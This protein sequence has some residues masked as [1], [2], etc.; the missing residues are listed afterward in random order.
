MRKY[1]F[2]LL[3]I[4]YFNS[5]FADQCS[6]SEWGAN[7]EIGNANLI[8]A[9]S[10]LKAS[11]LIKTGKTYSLGLIIDAETPAYPPRS[12]SL[13]V[14]QPTQQFG[15]LGLP[16]STYNDDIFQGW[17]G[18]GSQI[19]GLGHI[20]TTEAMFY[21]CNDGKE[22][23][24]ITGLTKL[25]IE[26]IPPIVARGIVV[27][28]AGHLGSDFID[29]GIT[30]NL[31]QLKE[32]MQSQGLSVEKGDVVL[33]HTGWT[34]AKFES[35]PAIWGAGAPGITPGIAEYLA[36][37][38]VIAV[39]ADT[40]SLDVVPPMIADEPY[41]AHG[42]LLQ[43]NGIYILESMNTGPLVK[44]EVK[45]FLFVLG[46]AKVRGAVQMIINPVAIN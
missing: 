36:S 22:F 33:L 10:V 6:H 38:D 15:V 32:A 4:L 20:G 42:I 44:D 7:D 31:P 18:I 24:Q 34:D 35:D 8:T 2:F 9:D 12:L 27:D 19:D 40:W 46:Q 21:N 5:S 39:G 37:K 14:V 26:K 11:K 29:A 3:S 1:I 16:N 25:G 43:E 17:F 41:P 13:Q 23:A 28:M 30:F 45:E